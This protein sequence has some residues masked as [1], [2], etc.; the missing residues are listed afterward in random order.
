MRYIIYLFVLSLIA[1]KDNTKSGEA[2]KNPEIEAD[3]LLGNWERINEQEGLQTFERWVKKDSGYVGIGWTM[4]DRDT[5]FKEILQIIERDGQ[6][7]LEIS[8]VNDVPTPFRIT[9]ISSESFVSENKENE[10]PK[11][12]EYRRNG[13]QLMAVISNPGKEIE[14]IFEEKIE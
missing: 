4:K 6:W 14:F 12:I 8:G 10:F 13:P 1:C 9:E 3:W 5:V 7:N 11:K 2:F